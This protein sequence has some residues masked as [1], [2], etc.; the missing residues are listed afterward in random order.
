MAIPEACGLW[1]EQRVQE[2]LDN[3]GDTGASLRKIG[4]Q[5][6]AEVERYFET[7]VNPR[8]IEKRAERQRATNVAPAQPTKTTIEKA[9]L[10]K[11]EKPQHGGARASAGRKKSTWVDL[12]RGAFITAVQVAWMRQEKKDLD[13][14]LVQFSKDSGI[15]KKLLSSWWHGKE[16]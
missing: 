2:E 3:R 14:I 16:R 13:K 15:P 4:R 10:K 7:K 11:L 8:T 6:A 1:I 5:V 9:T 12:C